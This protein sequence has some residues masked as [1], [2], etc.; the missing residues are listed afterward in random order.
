MSVF[1]LN[2]RGGE[3]REYSGENLTDEQHQA[4]EELPQAV[5]ESVMEA[6]K[7]REPFYRVVKDN[8]HP[9]FGVVCEVRS[10]GTVDMSRFDKYRIDVEETRKVRAPGC[11]GGWCQST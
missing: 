5:R 4:L 11:I 3:C 6:L 9:A 2:G 8:G 7:N 1:S 10:E